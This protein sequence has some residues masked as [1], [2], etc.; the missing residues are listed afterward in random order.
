MGTVEKTTGHLASLRVGTRFSNPERVEMPMMKGDRDQRTP[1][2]YEPTETM[3]LVAF[4]KPGVLIRGY[5][6]DQLW[7]G[8]WYRPETNASP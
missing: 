7:H 5:L 2:N 3:R 4:S 1:A 8:W 6:N